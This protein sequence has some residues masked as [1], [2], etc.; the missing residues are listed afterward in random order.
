MIDYSSR[1]YCR[2]IDCTIQRMID[3]PHLDDDASFAADF[4][5]RN[6]AA[7]NFHNWLQENGYKIVKNNGKDW[8]PEGEKRSLVA[9]NITGYNVKTIKYVRNFWPDKDVMIVRI[10][11]GQADVVLYEKGGLD[12]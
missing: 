6:C 7:Y 5:R 2:D 10:I 8:R 3:E 11:P 1:E 12:E 9:G 4:C